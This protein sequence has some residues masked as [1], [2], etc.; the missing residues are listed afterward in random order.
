MNRWT[1]ALT[2]GQM[3]YWTA[4]LHL[5]KTDVTKSHCS[6]DIPYCRICP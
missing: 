6:D 3:K 5:A 4:K 1:D 2:E